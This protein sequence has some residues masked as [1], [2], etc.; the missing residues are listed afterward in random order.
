LLLYNNYI[1][2]YIYL[3]MTSTSSNRIISIYKSRKTILELLDKQSYNVSEYNGF[4]INEI[5]A[6]F[7]NSQLDMLINHQTNSKKVYIKY[8]LSVNSTNKQ[9]RPQQLKDII[10]DLYELESILTKNDTLI[11][12]INDEP[13]DTIIAKLKYLYDHD[14]IFVVI[15]NVKRL[16]FNILQHKLI[17]DVSILT[18]PEVTNLKEKYNIKNVLQLPEIS[19]FDPLALA[20]CMRPNEVCKITRKSA[21]ALHSDFYRVCI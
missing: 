19:R 4:N 3:I 15:H 10:E 13:N 16:Q 8:Y 21:T 17:P 20:I 14:G 12:I 2:I 7:V 9:I 18:E 5:D 1:I 6:M 11:I